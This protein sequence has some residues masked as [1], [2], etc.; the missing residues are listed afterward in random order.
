[1][2]CGYQDRTFRLGV[3]SSLK[4]K[5]V[6]ENAKPYK[7]TGYSFGGMQICNIRNNKKKDVEILTDSLIFDGDVGNF[8]FEYKMPSFDESDEFFERDKYQ[9]ARGEL[10]YSYSVNLTKN[11]EIYTVLR[12]LCRLVRI[13]K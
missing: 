5:L 8:S 12:G 4:I 9:Y 6:D 2:I 11:G 10:L 7:L 3:C 13:A 1:M